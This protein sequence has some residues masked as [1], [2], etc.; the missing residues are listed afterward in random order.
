[1]NKFSYMN[2]DTWCL[3]LIIIHVHSE[4]KDGLL[5]DAALLQQKKPTNLS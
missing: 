2:F 5:Y 1:M 4:N 3:Q